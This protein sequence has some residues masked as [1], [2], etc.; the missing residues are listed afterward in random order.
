[1]VACCGSTPVSLVTAAEAPVWSPGGGLI[2]FVTTRA[3]GGI[4]LVHANGT[5]LSQVFHGEVDD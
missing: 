1:M 3:G 4:D 5:G 2:A